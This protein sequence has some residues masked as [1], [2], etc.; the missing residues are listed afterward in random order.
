MTHKHTLRNQIMA[1]A[2][3]LEDVYLQCVAARSSAP[4]MHPI[5]DGLFFPVCFCPYMPASLNQVVNRLIQH[6]RVLGD[7]FLIRQEIVLRDK[8]LM[9]LDAVLSCTEADSP[10]QAFA[11]NIAQRG[12]NS[13]II[14][15]RFGQSV[16]TPGSGDAYWL[17]L[18]F[19]WPCIEPIYISGLKYYGIEEVGA[20]CSEARQALFAAVFISTIICTIP[21]HLLA[22]PEQSIPTG[23]FHLLLAT[24]REQFLM[25]LGLL[26]FVEERASGYANTGRELAAISDDV[27]YLEAFHA[28][29]ERQLG[30]EDGF[31]NFHI[32]PNAGWIDMRR[33]LELHYCGNNPQQKVKG[34]RREIAWEIST[35][36]LH[37]AKISADLT[38]VLNPEYANLEYTK[39]IVK[40]FSPLI[41][42]TA[43]QLGNSRWKAEGRESNL[44]A[45]IDTAILEAN[46]VFKTAYKEYRFHFTEMDIDPLQ[47]PYGQLRQGGN[48]IV[49]VAPIFGHGPD[50]VDNKKREISFPHYAERKLKSWLREELKA[51][52]SVIS[53]DLD[54]IDSTDQTVKRKQRKDKADKWDGAIFTAP[55]GNKYITVVQ[56]AR[57]L[58]CP[59]HQLRRFDSELSVKRV[60]DIFGNNRPR[61][62][63]VKLKPDTRLYLLTPDLVH[64]AGRLTARIGN[65]A[66][67]HKINGITRAELCG[68]YS[69][70]KSTVISWEK[71][72]RL[73]PIKVG[74][75]VIYPPD[76]EQLAA[77]LKKSRKS[78]S[79]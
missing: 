71:K 66:A 68:R 3:Q 36:M 12:T 2:D 55:D 51:I 75:C 5:F 19:L 22:A 29:W 43:T 39:E 1:N 32:C 40:I 61:L 53:V 72:K 73:N 38:R 78:K 59:E 46:S 69:L 63:K 65:R 47:R 62:G 10:F 20:G 45:Y 14:L 42:G 18:E 49:R 9:S 25:M 23:Y 67:R 57:K 58:G 30:F 64:Q 54:D 17:L 24:I 16:I 48:S 74:D 33:Y 28:E 35:F 77:Q 4:K 50:A 8:R 37:Q 70:P 15:S 31:Y 76:Q 11:G 79:S 34:Y 21:I 13:D 44:Q 7:I 6:R 41:I 56:L 27:E 52:R 60:K 26:G